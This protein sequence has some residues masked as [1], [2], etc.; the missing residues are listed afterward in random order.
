MLEVSQ[1]KTP[2]GKTAGNLN[3]RIFFHYIRLLK[4]PTS[5]AN[6]VAR[7]RGISPAIH[8]MREL[9]GYIEEKI[10]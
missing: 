5:G 1:V 7:P 3:A 2:S 9:I 10:I 6:P 4:A 8:I